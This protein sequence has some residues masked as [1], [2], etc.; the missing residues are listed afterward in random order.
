MPEE[1][2]NSNSGSGAAEP[3]RRRRLQQ[4]MRQTRAKAEKLKAANLKKAGSEKLK[5]EARK[6]FARIIARICAATGFGLIITFLLRSV[7]AIGGN[8]AGSKLIAKLDGLGD[9]AWWEFPVWIFLSGIV[10]MAVIL[11][12]LML[13]PAAVFVS[14]PIEA[15]KLLPGIGGELIGIVGDFLNPF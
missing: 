15:A 4:K 13:A 11:V 3:G 2:N 7:Q 6:A 10:G 12:L 1:A 9:K 5:K 14:S 8:L